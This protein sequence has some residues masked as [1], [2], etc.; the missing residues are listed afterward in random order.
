MVK[1]T[2]FNANVT[3]TEGKIP[4]ISGSAT[5]SALTAAG[6][7]IPDVTIQRLVKLK[8]KLMITIM[9]NRLLLQNLILWR[10]MFLKKD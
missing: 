7:K 10:Q 9:I 8:I 4:S 1:E 5:N 3:E 6:N 2:D